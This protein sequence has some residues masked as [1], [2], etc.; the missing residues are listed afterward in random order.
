MTQNKNR[1]LQ[2]I[3]L[4][5]LFSACLTALF[6]SFILGAA[7]FRH[8]STGGN[9]LP[10]PVAKLVSLLAETPS[11]VKQATVEVIGLIN[12][13]PTPLLLSKDKVWAPNWEHKFPAPEDDGYLLLSGLSAH[14][15]QSTVKLIRIAD[16][17]VM[18]EWTPEWDL[19]HS[20]INSHRWVP[21]GSSRTYRA[22]H[23]LLLED[24]SLIFNTGSSLIRQPLCST[25]PNWVLNFPY[26]HS[27]ELAP[28]GKSVWV[29]S[30]TETFFTE[31]SI[32]KEKLRDDSLA[33][34]D[35]QG[36]I[37]KNLSFSRILVENGLGAHLLGT[38]GAILNNDP[39]HINQITPAKIDTQYWKRDDLLISAR[40]LS[41]IYI[42]R[43]ST[44]KIIWHQQ[45]PWFN[46]HS[47]HFLKN[48]GVTVFGN[49][50]YLGIS[51]SSFITSAKRNSIYL[52][53]FEAAATNELYPEALDRI[54]P[55]TITE[56]RA[57]ITNDMSAFIEE[58][59]NRRLM[60]INSK[61]QLQWSYINQYDDKNLG[62]VAW[63][64]YIT[65][66]ELE[67]TLQLSALQCK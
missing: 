10:Q 16:G 44:G 51:P 53:D 45:G 30:I 25:V 48:Y 66:N 50:V 34:V 39:I 57:H 31:N 67:S 41:T 60:K 13:A 56:G 7:M 12:N 17:S 24:G 42:Y 18:A 64:R 23:P 19:I 5:W 63:S 26:H 2:L 15:K 21:K 20:K 46:Q 33:Q 11:L 14:K 55:K 62:A 22:I 27:I 47:A 6:V 61:G 29:P 36:N 4:L 58:T 40:N 49:D 38:N 32:L 1:I 35:L 59:N 8:T 54:Q 43:P 37:L 3:F 52:H 65:R 28:D 9:K